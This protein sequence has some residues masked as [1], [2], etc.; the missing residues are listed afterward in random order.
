MPVEV[1]NSASVATERGPRKLPYL[2]ANKGVD[3]DHNKSRRADLG[4]LQV[5]RE[6][7]RADRSPLLSLHGFPSASHMFRDLITQLADEFDVIAPDLSRF[8]QSDMPSRKQ[9]DYTLEIVRMAWTL[10]WGCLHQSFRDLL[11]LV[12]VLD[13]G[14]LH[15]IR[16]ASV[17]ER[18][19]KYV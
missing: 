13:V 12:R 10:N 7:G 16:R 4:G 5:Y 6:T 17:S 3:Y 15:I 8:G 9:F 11:G 1:S 2:D 14:S 18:V 19:C